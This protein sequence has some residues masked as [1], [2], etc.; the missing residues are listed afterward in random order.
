MRKLVAVADRQR[1]DQQTPDTAMV[2]MPASEADATGPADAR[3]SA[4]SA[5]AS[6]ASH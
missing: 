3:P 1:L 6:V 5:F 2:V 4:A